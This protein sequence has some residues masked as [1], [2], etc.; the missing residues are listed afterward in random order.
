MTIFMLVFKD[1]ESK[2]ALPQPFTLHIYRVLLNEVSE[3][4]AESSLEFPLTSSR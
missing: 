3:V 2:A 1:S 4:R